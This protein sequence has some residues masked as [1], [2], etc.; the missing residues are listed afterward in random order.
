MTALRVAEYAT[1]PRGGAGRLWS[2][3]ALGPRQ[4]NGAK[5]ERGERVG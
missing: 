1:H 2:G 5:P 4:F 3:P